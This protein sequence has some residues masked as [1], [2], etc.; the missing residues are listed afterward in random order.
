MKFV[1][2]KCWP[3]YNLLWAYLSFIF[4]VVIRNKHVFRHHAIF[5]MIGKSN[6]R[7]IIKYVINSLHRHLYWMNS[8]DAIS[9]LKMYVGQ[10]KRIKTY[11]VCIRNVW[12]KWIKMNT[13]NVP[14]VISTLCI[15]YHMLPSVQGSF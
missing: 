3:N 14:L 15:E 13:V 4:G 7:D 9:S 2:L 10:R 11:S 6:I 1:S 8:N 5:L 12:T